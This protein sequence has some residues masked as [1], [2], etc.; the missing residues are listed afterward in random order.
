MTSFETSW[1]LKTSP[2]RKILESPD[3]KSCWHK[4][5]L[6]MPSATQK[7]IFNVK[8]T[9][10]IRNWT[11]KHISQLREKWIQQCRC[12]IGINGDN[13]IP[14][15]WASAMSPGNAN[16]TSFIRALSQTQHWYIRFLHYVRILAIPLSSLLLPSAKQRFWSFILVYQL[17][18]L[19]EE[20]ERIAV[21][22]AC[23][24]WRTSS[25]TSNSG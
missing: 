20:E 25:N 7:Y 23:I 1:Q 17:F 6:T 9:K 3:V 13:G 4:A 5:E 21:P 18:S 22:I 11:R 2:C 16:S 19:N 14:I 15:C 24:R 10:N 8:K 12:N